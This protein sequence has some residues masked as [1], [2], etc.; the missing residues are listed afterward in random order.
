[1]EMR[2]GCDSPRNLEAEAGH[3]YRG[4]L[5]IKLGQAGS[6]VEGTRAR[7]W[8]ISNNCH[9]IAAA[10][11]KTNSDPFFYNPLFKPTL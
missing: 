8:Q 3:S 2:V 1:M 4:T 7:S 11:L 5:T 9:Q 10:V 6:N